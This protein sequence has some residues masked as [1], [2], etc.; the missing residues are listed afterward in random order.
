MN[1]LF[2]IAVMFSLCSISTYAQK[3]QKTPSKAVLF[4]E[5]DVAYTPTGLAYKYRLDVPGKP[6]VIGD[7]VKLH[8]KLL[9]NKDSVL[10]LSLIHI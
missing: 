7:V 1:R 8:F 2:I 6:G 3:K 10:R 9:S 5:K 4:K